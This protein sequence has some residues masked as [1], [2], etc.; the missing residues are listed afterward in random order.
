MAF[1]GPLGVW[2]RQQRGL[3]RLQKVTSIVRQAADALQQMHNQQMVY[4]EVNPFN[5]LIHAESADHINVRLADLSAVR[6]YVGSSR[7]YRGNSLLVYMAP[8]QWMGF[9]VPATDQY[10]LAVLVYE[11]LTGQPPFQGPAAQL[12]D[13]HIN[14]QP[15]AP[16]TLNQQV[17]PAVD[18][19]ILSALAKRPED[20]FPSISAFAHALEE[21]MRRPEA[22]LVSVPRTAGD[23]NL[24]ATLLISRAEAETGTLR[25][26]TLPQGRRINVSVP[27]GAYEGQML[28]LEGFGDPSPTGGPPGVLMLTLA[29]SQDETSASRALTLQKTSSLLAFM[30]S[31]FSRARVPATR[32]RTGIASLPLR[33]VLASLAVLIVLVGA[34]IFALAQ[35]NAMPTPYPPSSGSLVLNDLLHDNSGGYDWPEGSSAVGSACQF[36]HGGYHVSVARTSS[37]YYC[38]AGATTFTNFAYEVRMTILKGDEG[39][40]I[41]R[42]DGASSKFYYFRVGRDGSYALYSYVDATGSHARTLASGITPTVHTGLNQANVL[43]VVAHDSSLALYINSQ[44]VTSITDKT[45]AVGQIG[46]AS[47]YANSATEVMFSNARVWAIA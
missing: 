7:S 20:R 14:I 15:A 35:S 11:L 21:A 25:T 30:T 9:A 10:A 31:A 5:L 44:P 26:I 34:G 45:Y 32:K 42:A 27:A 19:V 13:L 12:M 4:L 1:D 24:R 16:S 43:A 6:M 2:L 17:S 40:I 46:V 18:A 23:N 36:A 47:A 29:V 28:C 39:G 8:E 33:Y 37:L 22:L 41:F 38:I 3:P